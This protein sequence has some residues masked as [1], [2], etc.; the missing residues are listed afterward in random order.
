MLFIEREMQRHPAWLLNVDVV[1]PKY[2]CSRDP[3]GG[4]D[5]NFAIRPTHIGGGYSHRMTNTH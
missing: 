5:C 4:I 1:Y 3:R 2:I